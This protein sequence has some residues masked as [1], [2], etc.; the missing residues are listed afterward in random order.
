MNNR[1]KEFLISR[2]IKADAPIF[3][4]LLASLPAKEYGRLLP[5]LERVA[6]TYG[7]NIYERG[8]FIRS[9]YFVNSGIIA[10]LEDIGPQAAI[11]VGMIGNEGMIGLPIFLGVKSSLNRAIVQAAGFA[12][13]MKATKFLIACRD[14]EALPRLLRRFTHSLFAQVSQSAACHRF[15]P[16][17][18]RLARW[19]LMICDRMKSKDFQITQNFL[20][21][22]LGVRRE[23]V[24]K[25]AVGLQRQKLISYNRGKMLILDRA[26][27]EKISCPCY[28]VIKSEEKSFP[29]K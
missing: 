12:M 26:G 13:K 25:S 23:A 24:N 22:M 2:I 8:E 5:H 15:H 10:L 27:L 14:G 6:L 4:R 7:E 18:A 1:S 28:S 11:E 19:L 29:V 9:V 17:E 16:V 21:N 3:N 20:A